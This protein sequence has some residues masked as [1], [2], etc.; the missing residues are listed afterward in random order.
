MGGGSKGVIFMLMKRRLNYNI[1]G[2]IDINPDKQGKY[3]PAVGEKVLSPEE[4][5]KK[6]PEGSNCYVM[7]SNYLNEI[8][9]MS[10]NKY[11]YITID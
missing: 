8:K 7:N 11:N 3:I 10:K 2:I 1:D 4:G 9:Y 5:S 6:F